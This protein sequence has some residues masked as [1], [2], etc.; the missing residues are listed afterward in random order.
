[1]RIAREEIFGPVIAVIP[2]DDDA[3]AVRIANDSDYGLA[4]G[5]WSE[6]PDRAMAVARKVRSGMLHIN[7]VGGSFDA[8]FGGYKASG[9]GRESGREG[10]ETYFEYKSLPL[11]G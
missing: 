8:P 6:D 10:L 9:I 2:F 11:I 4:G 5:I 1:M 7:G 3:D